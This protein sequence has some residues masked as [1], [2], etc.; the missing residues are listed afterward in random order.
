MPRCCPGAGARRNSQ[1]ASIRR[2]GVNPVACE[3]AIRAGRQADSGRLLEVER[4]AAELVLGHGAH[5][6]FAMHSLSPQDIEEGIANGMLHVAEVQGLAVGFAL[7]GK[8][9]GHVHLFEM[10]VV[11]GHGRR[12][13]GS[14]LLEAACEEARARG[15]PSMT[16]VTLRDVPWNAPFYA[17][18][19]FVELPEGSWGPDLRKL[20]ERERMLGFLMQLRVVMQRSL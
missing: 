5:D 6:L 20:V 9:D 17:N 1:P 16:L 2:V 3:F 19:G 8:V 11:P 12:G 14:A 18:R 15:Y 4:L 10:D 13:I 7:H